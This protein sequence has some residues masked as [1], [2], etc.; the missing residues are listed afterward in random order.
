MRP[1]R[2]VG[3]ALIFAYLQLTL[4]IGGGAFYIWQVLLRCTEHLL[5]ILTMWA[6]ERT[7]ENNARVFYAL[8][9]TIELIRSGLCKKRCTNAE[10][11]KYEQAYPKNSN[12]PFHD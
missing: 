10:H 7:V 9:E 11:N 8:R 2:I 6:P 4:P 5:R 12:S 3:N 1:P